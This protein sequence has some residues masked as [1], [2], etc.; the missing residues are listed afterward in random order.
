MKIKWLLIAAIVFG[1]IMII[2]LSLTPSIGVI[3]KKKI[4]AD[5]SLVGEETI[6]E[7]GGL[8]SFS[9]LNKYNLKK[10]KE[11]GYHLVGK[12]GVFNEWNI[13]VSE[14]AQLSLDEISAVQMRRI[15][16]DIYSE[17]PIVID[18]KDGLLFR[19][20]EGGEWV[21]LLLED[22]KLITIALVSNSADL[23]VEEEFLALVKSVKIK[24]LVPTI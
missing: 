14:T 2:K 20:K 18:G 1:A 17:E 24:R 9:Y 15:K 22:G 12:T 23:K 3:S 19:K 8:I 5:A 4:P 10:E 13:V 11:N 16:T 21:S 6:R 7:D